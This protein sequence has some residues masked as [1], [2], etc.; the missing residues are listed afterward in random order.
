MIFKKPIIIFII[1]FLFMNVGYGLECEE[2]EV[3]LGWGE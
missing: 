1:L 3:D 2:A